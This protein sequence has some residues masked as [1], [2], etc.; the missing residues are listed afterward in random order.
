MCRYGLSGRIWEIEASLQRHTLVDFCSAVLS[1]WNPPYIF[2]YKCI[3]PPSITLTVIDV[4]VIKEATLIT[5]SNVGL[6]QVYA[7]DTWFGKWFL[8][9]LSNI[10]WSLSV[11]ALWAF[12]LTNIWHI[13]EIKSCDPS[14]SSSSA[15]SQEEEGRLVYLWYQSHRKQ[16]EEKQSVVPPPSIDYKSWGPGGTSS[17]VSGLNLWLCCS[18]SAVFKVSVQDSKSRA[19]HGCW[20]WNWLRVRNLTC[21]TEGKNKSGICA[22]PENIAIRSRELKN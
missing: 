9:V 12:C 3:E 5:F 16:A 21:C 20:E 19:H 2:P 14:S 17:D 22:R 13:S 8:P 10:H 7:R 1:N 11:L 6:V 15:S 18:A 4:V